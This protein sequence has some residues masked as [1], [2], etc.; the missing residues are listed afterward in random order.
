MKKIL[1]ALTAVSILG[2]ATPVWAHSDINIDVVNSVFVTYDD[3]G[4]V[5]ALT[6]YNIFESNFGDLEAGP[7]GTDDPG[8]VSVGGLPSGIILGYR[9]QGALQ[10]WN[11][12]NWGSVAGQETVSITDAFGEDSIFG[13]SG[14]SGKL[15]GLID[16][17]GSGGNL[18]SHLDFRIANSIGTPAV[19]AYAILL[20]VLGLDVYFNPLSGYAE[21]QSF[22]LVFN[23]GLS[24]EAFESAIDA[25]VSAVPIPAAGPL[26]GAALLVAFGAARRHSARLPS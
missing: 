4:H 11:G 18:H 3:H 7:F 26:F 25:R 13:A 1:A 2:L 24:E 23:R 22:Y 5:D 12:S 6:G 10:F 16:Q 15:V 14:P 19:G 21:S 8:F 20:S 17:V 9:A